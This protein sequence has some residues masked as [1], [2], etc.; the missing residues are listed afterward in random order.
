MKFHSAFALC[1]VIAALSLQPAHA[2]DWDDAQAA[3][4][5]YD[6]ATGLALLERAAHQGDVRA[7]HAW[8]LALLHGRRLFPN[9]PTGN[10]RRAA[11]WFD[12]AALLC[13]RTPASQ[14]EQ[15]DSRCPMLAPVLLTRPRLTPAA[16]GSALCSVELDAR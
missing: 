1:G 2:D 15:A 10:P 16:Q 9:M 13:A 12:R 11:E 7:M 14:V 8:G 6:N 3:F 5:D 4:S